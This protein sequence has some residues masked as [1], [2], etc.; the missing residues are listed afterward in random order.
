MSYINNNFVEF[1]KN[2]NQAS[3][4][5]SLARQYQNAINQQIINYLREPMATKYPIDVLKKLR[6]G[7]KSYKFSR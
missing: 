2:C 6:D 7:K 3:Y 4:Y 5:K 1:L